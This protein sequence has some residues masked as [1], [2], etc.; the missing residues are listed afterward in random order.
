MRL[1]RLGE[2]RVGLNGG[3]ERGVHAASAAEP[4]SALGLNRTFR[5]IWTVKRR[6]RRA[7]PAA[8]L[9]RSGFGWL[10]VGSL[11]HVDPEN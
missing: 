10:A 11:C 4:N 7:P 2:L 6:E 1:K 3:V 5:R 9:H 8:Q